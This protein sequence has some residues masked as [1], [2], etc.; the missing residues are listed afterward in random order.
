MCVYCSLLFCTGLLTCSTYTPLDVATATI[1]GNRELA[2]ALDE[3]HLELVVQLLVATTI[4][5]ASLTSS[6]DPTVDY[7]ASL[8]KSGSN[9]KHSPSFSFE[10]SPGGGAKC[11]E[12]LQTV[13]W[14]DSESLVVV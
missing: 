13:V 12:F 8:K 4:N 6:V 2:L 9:L 11:L 7:A 5:N 14:V 3:S 1:K 10:W